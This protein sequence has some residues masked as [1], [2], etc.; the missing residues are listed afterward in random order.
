MIPPFVIVKL[1]FLKIKRACQ[2]NEN[3][4][5]KVGAGAMPVNLRV[6]NEDFLGKNSYNFSRLG[7]T[8]FVFVADV[9]QQF[10]YE[11]E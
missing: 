6:S 10:D 1:F 9:P 8:N 5:F 7:H 11:I 4:F 3:S 2:P